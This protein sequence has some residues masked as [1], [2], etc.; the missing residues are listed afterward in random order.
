[1]TT[2]VTTTFQKLADLK[3]GSPLLAKMSHLTAE[4]GE[5]AEE[6]NILH[7]QPV[8][9]RPGEDGIVGEAID[10][11]L[12][13]LDIVRMINPLI[14]EKEIEEFASRKLAKWEATVNERRNRR[15]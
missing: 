9:K 7:E 14:T 10:V 1:M 12:C 2:L 3:E 6:I 13:A 15:I 4:V 5:L 11:I 8:N